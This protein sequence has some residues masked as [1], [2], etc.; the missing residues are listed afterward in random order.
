MGNTERLQGALAL[1]L[2]LVATGPASA[3][4]VRLL[5]QDA[6]VWARTV[7]LKGLAD[8]S[9]GTAG[10]VIVNGS[11]LPVSIAAPG[12][13][14]H[15]DIPIDEGIN[16]VVAVF[17]SAGT[18]V[19]S[20]T[21]TLTLGYRLRPDLEVSALVSGRSV[22]LHAALLENPGNDALTF[23]WTEHASNPSV[24]GLV[25][26]GDSICQV[27]IPAGAKPGE[28]VFGVRVA[29]GD[30]DT[31]RR[32][33]LVRVASDSVGAM[34]I[35][36]ERPAWVD[37]AVVYGITPYIFV[38][39]GNL[40]EITRKLPEL[41]DF[42]VNTLW[43][44]PVFGTHGGGQ[45][46]DIID[47]FKVRN[48]LGDEAALRTLVQTAHSYGLRVL[49]DFVPNHT[50]I[51]HSYAVQSAQYGAASHYYDFYQ[52]EVDSAPYSQ[53]YKFYQG[54]INYFWDELPNL[55][56]DNPEVRRM[57]LEAGRYWVEAFDIDGYRIDAVWGVNA[58]RP[59]FMQDWRVALKHVKPDILLLGEDKATWPSVFDQRFDAAYDWA[60]E[61]DWVSHW[62]WQPAYSSTSN[63]TIF[64]T[65]SSGQRSALLRKAL[66]NNGAG[67]A[68]N[69][70][71][72]HFMENND[73]FRFLPT[74]DLARTKMVA[75]LLMS[76]P[77]I[78][79]I[80]NGQEVGA[81]THPYSTTMIFGSGTTI[82]LQDRS[83]L[84]L[85]YRRLTG[86]RNR[87]ESLRT[88][89]YEEIPITP[90]AAVFGYRRWSESQQMF[91]L[92]NMASSLIRA[93]ARLPVDRM[94]LDPGRSYVVTDLLTDQSFPA[95]AADLDTFVVDLPPYTSRLYIVDT[96]A[97]TAV[98]DPASTPPVP[99]EFALEQNY[100]NPFN[101]E[102]ILQFRI[103]EEGHVRLVVYDLLGREVA[104]LVDELKEPGG[105]TVGFDA[106]RLASGMYLARVEAGGRAIVRK[107]L[108]MR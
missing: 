53:H 26:G 20:D 29:T 4:S 59:E 74:H 103:A 17:D 16:A 37:D 22:T 47:Y 87:F 58:R 33:A 77:G 104:T 56:Y 21:L 81:T 55:N 48:D 57:M 78:P 63:P 23:L 34:D 18:P 66:T 79:L 46:Y 51:H 95:T 61:T 28:Y 83:G 89:N 62:T 102:T 15:V 82:E 31:V 68:P 40:E 80:Y 27:S 92:M 2:L 60:P 96:A 49:L 67:Y 97:V 106:S 84:Y 76:L 8:P 9:L 101:G 75:A 105:Y 6:T 13:T 14:F 86:I 108:L 44:Q 1:A 91:L 93:S 73:T 41:A 88:S 42:G 30:G 85:V 100:P 24:V 54:F 45:G 69:A 19:L 5:K 32:A 70:V 3:G 7:H 50:S 12:D 39:D 65:S 94:G 90:G 52:R 98:D 38:S 25:S 107:M 35:R 64:N 43:I 36:T 10:S 71:V 11:V 99:K 72:M